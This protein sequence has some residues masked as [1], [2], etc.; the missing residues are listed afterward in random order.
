MDLTLGTL[1]A[2]LITA[3]T[4]KDTLPNVQRFVGGN[5]AG[6]VDHMVGV[7]RRAAAPTG[8]PRCGSG[9]RQQPHVT[10]VRTGKRVVGR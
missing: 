1:H 6:G 4:V 10:A 8:R 2:M 3:S 9:S 5:L 7:P